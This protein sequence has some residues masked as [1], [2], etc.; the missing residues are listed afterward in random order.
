M[1]YHL[2]TLEGHN[3]FLVQMLKLLL[4]MTSMLSGK[5]DLWSKDVEITF[6]YQ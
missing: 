4:S 1:R 3:Q 2:S 5:E 6:M